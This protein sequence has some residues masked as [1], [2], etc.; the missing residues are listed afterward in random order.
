MDFV[1]VATVSEVMDSF[2]KDSLVIALG[3]PWPATDAEKAEFLR[4]AH[5]PADRILSL[6][7]GLYALK[8]DELLEDVRIVWTGGSVREAIAAY[9]AGSLPPQHMEKL[10]RLVPDMPRVFRPDEFLPI[11]YRE[12][13]GA[14]LEE[15]HHH[16]V[17]AGIANVLPATVH[18]FLG[19]IGE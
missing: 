15:G 1:R 4:E 11:G 9:H 8:R 10:R 12:P 5:R 6:R 13:C 18:I 3:K 17:A 14:L 2:H 16:A 19:D 7:W